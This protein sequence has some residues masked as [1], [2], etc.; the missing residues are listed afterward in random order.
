MMAVL[1]SLVH[2]R[3]K[4]GAAFLALAALAGL[5]L[6]VTPT[7]L[8]SVHHNDPARTALLTYRVITKPGG[9]ITVK[10]NG[11]GTVRIRGHAP[12]TLGKAGGTVHG[13]LRGTAAANTPA[14]D[15]VCTVDADGP[16]WQEYQLVIKGEGVQVCSG[17]GWKPQ[18][19]RVAV[20]WYLGLGFWSNR[21]RDGSSFSD[22]STVDYTTFYDCGGT[23]VHTYRIVVNGYS[24]NGNTVITKNSGSTSLDCSS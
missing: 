11:S 21:A 8:A 15:Y 22:N 20:Q 16:Y 9:S 6:T 10:L 19:V 12:V 23:G 2:I 5:G 1:L 3:R 7:A 24:N 17:S 14:A 13:Q 4:I 18:R